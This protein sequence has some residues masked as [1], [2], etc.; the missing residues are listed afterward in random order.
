[1]L[2]NAAIASATEQV[3]A[4]VTSGAGWHPHDP[5]WVGIEGAS[6]VLREPA[7]WR[8]AV[9]AHEVLHGS[10]RTALELAAERIEDLRRDTRLRSFG[11]AGRYS[12]GACL[13]L[14][15]IALPFDRP[16]SA[17]SRWRDAEIGGPRC[18]ALDDDAVA[19][20]AWAPRTPMEVW[21]L[22]RQGTAAFTAASGR[23]LAAL[24]EQVLACVAAALSGAVIDIVLVEGEPWRLELRPRLTSDGVFEAATGVPAHGTFP[25]EATA[26]LHDF[27][28]TPA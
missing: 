24:T 16:P 22:P 7:V 4:R 3:S 21:V 18:L 9:G 12:G 6:V 23:R 13:G 27:F 1:M 8:D 5:P 19:L 11:L 25:E 14:E 15:L 26:F 28:P 20:L 2:I 10:L 17:P